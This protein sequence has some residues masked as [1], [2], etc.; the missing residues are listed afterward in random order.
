MKKYVKMKKEMLKLRA[1][2][3]YVIVFLLIK[4]CYQYRVGLAAN[5]K[6]C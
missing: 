6:F 4:S 2:Y 3:R 1:A 5:A